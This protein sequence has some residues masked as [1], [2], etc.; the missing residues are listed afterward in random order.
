MTE[1]V[2]KSP[3]RPM[4]SAILTLEAIVLG[5]TAPVLIRISH[6][7]AGRAIPIALGLCVACILTAGLLKRPWA[8]ALGWTIQIAA[9]ALGFLVTTMFTLGIIFGVLW[10]G[11]LALSNKIDRER[12][13]AYAA[14]DRATVDR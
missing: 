12:E 4:A 13:A 5:L 14:H 8:Y 1:M 9:I 3:R 2:E 11:A 7:S 6:V 10:W